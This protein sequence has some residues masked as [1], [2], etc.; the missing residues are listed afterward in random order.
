MDL[1]ITWFLCR[2]LLSPDVFSGFIHAVARVHTLAF[3]MVESD[4]IYPFISRWALW[5]FFPH[6]WA[7]GATRRKINA[8]VCETRTCL[9]WVDT[10]P[11]VRLL[12]RT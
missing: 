10:Y 3:L 8:R 12:G 7:L 9:S 1:Y 11:R 6:F 5:D 4:F 2:G